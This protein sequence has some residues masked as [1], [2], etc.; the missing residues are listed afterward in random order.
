MACRVSGPAASEPQA[1]ARRKDEFTRLR[2]GLGPGAAQAVR[3]TVRRSRSLRQLGQLGWARASLS[4]AQ[5]GGV[6]VTAARAAVTVHRQVPVMGPGITA[7]AAHWQL[8]L[9]QA[10]RGSR[11]RSLFTTPSRTRTRMRPVAATSHGGGP[12]VT[13]PGHHRALAP[14]LSAL[15]GPWPTGTAAESLV[16]GSAGGSRASSRPARAVTLPVVV[17]LYYSAL[18]D[19][20]SES[21][22]D[23]EVPTF[24]C[25][26]V[27]GSPATGGAAS[28]ASRWLLRLGGGPGDGNDPVLPAHTAGWNARGCAGSRQ[29]RAT[30][31]ARAS[32]LGGGSSGG[33]RP[34]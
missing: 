19:S 13:T 11:S 25:P 23:S 14:R 31:A 17:G 6:T 32:G 7:V 26:T 30:L 12:V 18:S 22:S 9:R 28:R 27:F 8:A 5:A 3:V 2:D 1:Q 33:A 10:G 20:G 16:P 24:D 34:C 4:Q 15:P 29:S 21:E